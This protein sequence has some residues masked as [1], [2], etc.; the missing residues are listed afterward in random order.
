MKKLRI[1]VIIPAYNEQESI[2]NTV[3]NLKQ[4]CS[5]MEHQVDYVVINDG[6]K[7]NTLNIL[8]QNHFSFIDLPV[9]LGIGGGM[10]TGYLYA[11]QNNYDIAI[12]L[13]G[14][15]QHLSLIHI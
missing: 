3:E 5:T 7:D 13:D 9:N 14:D 4:A 2:Q 6:S 1:L 11:Y 12:Q 10:Q 15:G 8:K